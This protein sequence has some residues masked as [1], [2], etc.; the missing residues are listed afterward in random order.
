MLQN[1]TLLPLIPTQA[2]LDEVLE[3]YH[4]CED[5][6]ALGPVPTASMSMVEADL[7]HS[8]QEGGLFCGI[9][10]PEHVMMGIIDYVLSGYQ[11]DPGAAFLSLLMIAAPYRANGLGAQV[12]H[13]FEERVL[14]HGGVREIFSGVQVNNPGAVR[15]WRRMGYQIISGPTLLPDQTTVYGL[16]KAVNK[17]EDSPQRHQGH[18]A[19]D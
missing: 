9:Y 13:T 5:F 10:S 7:E 17:E 11:S 4:Q 16:W 14:S 18:K 15:F 19:K 8:R 1:F 2:E 6:L 12:V 3:V